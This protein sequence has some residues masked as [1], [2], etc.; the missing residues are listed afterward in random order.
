MSKKRLITSALP[1]V[2]NEPHLGNII[3]CVLS[4]DCYARYSRSAGHETLYICGTDE[5]GTAT[6]TKATQEG[7]TPREICD[8]Y[9]QIHADIYKHFNISFDAF[10]RTSTPEHTEIVQWVFDGVEKNNFVTEVKSEQFYCKP[11]DKFL[12]DRLVKGAC[13]KCQ[14]ADAK[15][16]QCDGCGSMLNPTELV[17]PKCS[18]CNGSP[19]LKA[20]EH[21]HLDLPKIKGNLE[22]FQNKAIDE[23]FWPNNAKTTTQSWMTSRDLTTRAITRDLKWGV[24]VPKEGY[25]DKVFYVWFDAPIGYVSITRKAFPDTWKDWWLAPDNTELY[26]F[27]AKDNIPF[28]SIIFPATQL[29]SGEDW[30]MVHHLSST[31][32]LNYEDTKFSKSN[33][34]GVFGGDVISSGI[35][36]DL[37]RFYL[38]AVRPERQDT[39]FSWE[40][41]FTNVNKNFI[42]NIGNLVNRSLVFSKKSFDGKIDEPA[43]AEE[44]IEF[45]KEIHDLQADVTDSF[46]KVGL[47]EALRLILKISQAGNVFFDKQEPW[48]RIKE[49]PT[50]AATTLSILTH[51]VKDIAIMLEPFMPSTSAKIFKMLDI[52]VQTWEQLGQFDSLYGHQTLQPEILFKKLDEKLIETYKEKYSGGVKEDPW[53]KVELKVGKIVEIDNHPTAGHL[54]VEKIDLGGSEP[55]TIA[56]GLVKYFE[57]EDLLNKHVLVA[58]N[59]SAAELSGVKS[60]GMVLAVSKKKKMEVIDCGNAAPGTV[61]TREGEAPTDKAEIDITAFKEAALRTIDGTVSVD[62]EALFAGDIA[63]KTELVL[64]GKIG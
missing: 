30:T 56:S 9:H 21:L 34:V 16:D 63:L 33:N 42:N 50:Y 18:V 19:E 23:G 31:E 62:G 47:K 43:Y 3:G 45:M 59:L 61:I 38:L 2:N 46:E 28:H 51:L 52:D 11:C 41:F 36:A 17:S 22:E 8:K 32:Y 58:S 6:E 57:K 44:H 13:P 10:G 4:A 35:D 26:Q 60:Q 49:D 20:T 7:L 14:F 15:G 39:A 54:Y 12:A 48:K 37:W 29:A 55:V 24:P 25:T 1:Y 5:Y 40:D 27:M 64:N 53:E